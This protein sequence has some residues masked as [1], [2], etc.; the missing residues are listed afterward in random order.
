M[1]VDWNENFYPKININ[2]IGYPQPFQKYAYDAS[3]N[4]IVTHSYAK[5]LNI[6]D[7]L[8][9]NNIDDAD[10]GTLLCC[11]THFTVKVKS[12][13]DIV[14]TSTTENNV[15]SNVVSNVV[16]GNGNLQV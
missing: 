5:S 10:K 7:E 3:A 11:R 8:N 1:G 13:S 15:I 14:E 9:H 2:G 16:T 6:L 12:E 4:K